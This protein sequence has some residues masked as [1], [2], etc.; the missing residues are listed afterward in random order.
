MSCRSAASLQ[1]RIRSAG[2]FVRGLQHH[3]LL[4][5]GEG[6]LVHVLVVVV[7]VLLQPQHRQFRKDVLGQAGVD[8]ECQSTSGV[9]GHD[10]LH[11]LLADPLGG[12][13]GQPLGLSRHGGDHVRCH[14]EAELRR[15]P[16]RAHHA[17]RIVREGVMRGPWRADR[18]R[19]QVDQPAEVI[20]EGQVGQ[21]HRHR[22]DGEVPP[23]EVATEGVTEVDLRLARL[24]VVLLGSVG[25]DL[26]LTAMHP[27]TDRA[28]P[29]PDVP[30]GLR[31]ALE[32]GQHRLGASIGREVQISLRR[33]GQPAEQGIANRPTDEGQLMPRRRETVTDCRQQAR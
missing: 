27:S 10:D 5:D 12:H 33:R 25:R 7:L 26:H 23:T 4:K 6:V 20:N 13:D 3:R 30:R 16:G 18:A 17:Q 8:E 31:E 15:E 11:E 32:E 2:R 29:D 19:R 21:P 22:V 28:E 1:H 14:R 24:R 9:G